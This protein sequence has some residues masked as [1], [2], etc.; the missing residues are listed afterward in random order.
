[1]PTPDR[2][3]KAIADAGF[4]VQLDTDFDVDKFAGF[5][6]CKYKGVETGFEYFASQLS[7][8]ERAE[9]ELPDSCDFGVTLVTHADLREAATALVAASVLCKIAGGVFIDPQRVR[10]GPHR[11]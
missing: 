8:D 2:W 6:P 10:R 9:L 5:L 3:A 11:T 7:K 4:D 1:M